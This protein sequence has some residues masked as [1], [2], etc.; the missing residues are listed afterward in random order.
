M[1]KNDISIRPKR[2]SVKWK[3]FDLCYT[4]YIYIL[5][6]LKKGVVKVSP[7]GVK[8]VHATTAARYDDKLEPT[9]N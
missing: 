7:T 3:W 6:H 4:F 8:E 5:Y 1:N 2:C 9:E